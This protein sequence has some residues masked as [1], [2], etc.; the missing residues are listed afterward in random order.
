LTSVVPAGK[1]RA[2]LWFYRD[3]VST[4][5]A[6]ASFSSGG[7]TQYYGRFGQAEFRDSIDLLRNEKPVSF[8]WNETSNGVFLS[9]GEEPVGEAELP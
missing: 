9:T 6:N 3:S 2:T 5:S 1:K 8:Q 7:Y 4:I